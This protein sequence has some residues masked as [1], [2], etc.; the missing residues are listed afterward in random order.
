MDKLLKQLHE[1]EKQSGVKVRKLESDEEGNLLLDSNNPEDVEWLEND[2]V[3]DI[4]QNELF[5]DQ[6][7]NM[8]SKDKNTDVIY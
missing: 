5:V 6:H 7:G 1:L 3:Y 2:S 8:I 4:I